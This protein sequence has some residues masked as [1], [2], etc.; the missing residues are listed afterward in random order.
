MT[1]A[2]TTLAKRNSAA[3]KPLSVVAARI[4]Q[5]AL[6][7]DVELTALSKLAETDPGFASRVVASVNSGTFGISRKV[8]DVKQASSML[9]VRGLRNL[10]LSL[11]V[12]D[13]VPTG[14]DGNVLLANSLRRAVAAKALAEA[15]KTPKVDEFF[16]AGLFLDVGLLQTARD[17]LHASAEIA[18]MP[19]AHRVTC[20]RAYGRQEHPSMGAEFVQKLGLGNEL[21]EAVAHHHE[22]KPATSMVAR[23]TWAA[24]RVAGAFEGGDVLRTKQDALTACRAIG[25]TESQ[26]L[27]VFDRIPTLVSETAAAFDRQV[28]E[29]DN[30]DAL[31][32]NANVRLVEMNG[33][34]ERILQRLEQLLVEK[35]ALASQLQRANAELASVAA[36]DPLTGLP[37]R[38]AFEEALKR[39][40]SRTE[41]TGTSMALLILDIDFFKKVNDTYGHGT[42][43]VV[44]K[45][46]AEVL[47]RALRTGDIP[48]RI[49]GEEFVAIL[50]GSDASGGNIVAERIR[51]LIAAAK[52]PGPSGELS[53]TASFG[54]AA[55]T[56]SACRGAETTLLERADAALY[57]AKR[58][59]RNRVVLAK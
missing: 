17:D 39:D 49:G 5:E 47:S 26:A 14:A 7:E 19:S 45:K 23:I 46:V 31:V 33:N 22:P 59:G 25:L 54:V 27:D 20:E 16:T 21:A 41:R 2:A 8:T 13:M 1:A 30:L 24:E 34:Y 42:G 58:S 52:V 38:R 18:R 32:A 6:R 40:L 12:S 15:M 56:G 43:D 11:V 36:T 51:N 37:N 10:A 3:S 48:A 50:P 57:E 44:I 53:V 9:G 55:V 35:D 28:G 29:Q 4:V